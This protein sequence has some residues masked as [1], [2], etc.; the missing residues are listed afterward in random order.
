MISCISRRIESEVGC[1]EFCS[2]ESTFVTDDLAQCRYCV[3]LVIRCAFDVLLD[4]GTYRRPTKHGFSGI[5]VRFLSLMWERR[6]S[7]EKTLSL[8]SAPRRMLLTHLRY[9]FRIP[10]LDHTTSLCARIHA[11]CSPLCARLLSLGSRTQEP[12]SWNGLEFRI[13]FFCREIFGFGAKNHFFLPK[14]PYVAIFYC[15]V[16]WLVCCNLVGRCRRGEL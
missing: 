2:N 7:L 11:L 8:L 6:A 14:I 4:I 10:T 9:K 1:G 16:G 3:S 13:D 12:F 15:L 5:P